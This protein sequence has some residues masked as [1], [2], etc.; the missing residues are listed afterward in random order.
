MFIKT[1][2]NRQA[3]SKQCPFTNNGKNCK[4]KNCMAWVKVYDEVSREDH[5]GG[6]S[7][8]LEQKRKRHHSTGELKRTGP[9]GCGGVYTLEAEGYCS[10]AYPN[11]TI[12]EAYSN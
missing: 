6:S 4:H 7:F 8:I 2:T 11:D 1:M 5:S 12:K 9:S 3:S 10:M